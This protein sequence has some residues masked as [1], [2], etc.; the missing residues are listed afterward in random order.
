M[1]LFLFHPHP[2]SLYWCVGILPH[3]HALTS[4]LMYTYVCLQMCIDLSI[5][6]SMLSFMPTHTFHVPIKM[7]DFAFNSSSDISDPPPR[8]CLYLPHPPKQVHIF[9]CLLQDCPIKIKRIYLN[10]W[11]RHRGIIYI[12][13]CIHVYTTSIL[14]NMI[15]IIIKIIIIIIII[16]IQTNNH[17]NN[18]HDNNNKSKNQWIQTS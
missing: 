4:L 1:S 7:L 2:D 6:I 15:I 9:V 8:L 14:K 10:N 18:N 13:V 3:L 16:N 5:H 11:I 12:C 17:N